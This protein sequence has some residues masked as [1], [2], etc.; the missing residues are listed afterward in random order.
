MNKQKRMMILALLA[1]LATILSGCSHKTHAQKKQEM[2]QHWE[3]S[4][5]LAKMPA[6]KNLLDQGKVRAAKKELAKCLAVNPDL[7]EAYLLTGRVHFLEGNNGK[8]RESFLRAVEL[9]PEIHQAWHFLGSLSLLDKDFF[10]AAAA[11]ETAFKLVPSNTDYMLSVIDICVETEQYEKAEQRIEQG[12]SKNPQNLE[13]LLSKALLYQR[14][15]RPEEAIQVYEQAQLMHGDI[16]QILESV[17]YAYIAQKEWRRAAEKFSLLLDQYKDD[18]DRYNVTMRSLATSLF[19]SGQY[20]KAL[21]WYDKLSLVYREDADIWLHMAHAA[22]TL[23]DGKRAAYSAVNAL[24][25]RP[26]WNKAYAILGGANY[27][28][29]LYHQSLQAFYE[30][31]DDEELGAFAWFMTGRCYQRLGRNRQANVAFERSEELDP[32]NTMVSV[33]LKKTVH[34]L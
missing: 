30:I 25:I 33:L 10:N 20:G 26:N 34:P 31:T 17:G 19:N 23:N 12:L 22:L 32:D 8:A 13:L 4:T 11:F 9:D 14:L 1:G 6:I 5:S 16:P 3:Q 27:V 29:G 21:F 7:A 2:V 24:K 18:K 28:Q 15:D